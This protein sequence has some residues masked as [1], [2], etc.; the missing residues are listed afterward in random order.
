MSQGNVDFEYANSIPAISI[1][2]YIP[3]RILFVR[4]VLANILNRSNCVPVKLCDGPGPELTSYCGHNSMIRERTIL[5]SITQYVYVSIPEKL[6]LFVLI[7]DTYYKKPNGTEYKRQSFSYPSNMRN[8][9]Q[10]F[11]NFSSP[12]ITRPR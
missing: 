11:L 3:A 5:K 8:R 10:S 2:C 7:S 1:V 6:R 12:I 9:K 4:F